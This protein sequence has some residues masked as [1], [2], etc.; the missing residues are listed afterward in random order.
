MIDLNLCS[1]C[2]QADKSC[3]VYSSSEEVFRCVEWRPSLGILMDEFTK[4]SIQNSAVN[5]K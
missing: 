2:R 4:M 5:V 1:K 3:P